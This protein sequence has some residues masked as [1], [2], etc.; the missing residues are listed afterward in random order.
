MDGGQR[1][2]SYNKTY[3]VISALGTYAALT[4]I[5]VEISGT[6]YTS[7]PRVNWLTMASSACEG[8][9]QGTV[10]LLTSF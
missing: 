2:A 3:E 1:D 5:E 6:N 4:I 9:V 7:V 8:V 10:K